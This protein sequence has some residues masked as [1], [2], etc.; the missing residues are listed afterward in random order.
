[1]GAVARSGEGY[2]A[3]QFYNNLEWWAIF[4]IY[5]QYSGNTPVDKSLYCP[6]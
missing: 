6:E 2:L 4:T 5:A 1:M 3:V